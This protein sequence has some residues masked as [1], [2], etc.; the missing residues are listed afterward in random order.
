MKFV[1]SIIFDADQ[2]T[3]VPRII[4]N[5]DTTIAFGYGVYD[6]QLEG[7]LQ[8]F[9]DDIDRGYS[10]FSNT[11]KEYKGVAK[12]CP[13]D[14]YDEKRGIKIASKKAEY[15]A[16][17]AAYKRYNNILKKLNSLSGAITEEMNKINKR[18]VALEDDFKEELSK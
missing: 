1:D 3:Y 5:G 6:E 16:R 12:L 17:K 9:V 14:V 18:L 13:G 2:L 15:R 4:K 8:R 10:S 11:G 7:K